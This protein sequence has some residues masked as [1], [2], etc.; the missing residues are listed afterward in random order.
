M[1]IFQDE[2]SGRE[3]YPA[4][5]Y[6]Y[7]ES[8]P[9]GQLVVDFN[10]AFSPPCNYSKVFSCPL[11]RPANRLPVAIPAGEKWYRAARL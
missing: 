4:A 9:R 8:K 7:V 1:L 2:T 6:L 3:S 10:R 11:P 5:R